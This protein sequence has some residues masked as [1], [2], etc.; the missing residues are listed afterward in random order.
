MTNKPKTIHLDNMDNFNDLSRQM[1]KIDWENLLQ[2][3][4]DGIKFLILKDANVREAVD[5]LIIWLN[6]RARGA[7]IV[8][9]DEIVEL[10][11]TQLITKPM[12]DTFF[13]NKELASSNSLAG[14]MNKIFDA[15][16]QYFLLGANHLK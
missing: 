7:R 15:M 9:K 1:Q 14:K 2:K 13:A 12:F 10:L 3:K 11:A 6:M 8:S 4:K 5:E 16:R